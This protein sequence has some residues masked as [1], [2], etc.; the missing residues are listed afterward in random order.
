MASTL[1]SDLWE[2]GEGV[3]LTLHFHSSHHHLMKS[4][5]DS[6]EVSN[7]EAGAD[8]EAIKDATHWLAHP[9]LLRLLSYRMQDH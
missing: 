5:Q 9:G 7:P 3:A 6:K 2:V 8:T 4:A 1:P